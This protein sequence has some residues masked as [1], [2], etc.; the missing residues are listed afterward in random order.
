MKDPVTTTYNDLRRGVTPPQ[1]AADNTLVP[2]QFTRPFAGPCLS[3]LGGEHEFCVMFADT[4][5][6]CPCH[7]DGHPAEKID[8]RGGILCKEDLERASKLMLQPYTSRPPYDPTRP[9][10]PVGNGRKRP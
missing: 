7:A 3:C 9:Q 5:V 8:M 6:G 10:K 2:E 4:R 1:R